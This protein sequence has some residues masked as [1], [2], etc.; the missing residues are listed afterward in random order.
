M[1]CINIIIIIFLFLHVFYLNLE[2]CIA[3]CFRVNGNVGQINE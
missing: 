2:F 1:Y 3:L